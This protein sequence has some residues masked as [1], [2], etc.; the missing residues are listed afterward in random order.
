MTD[1]F[2]PSVIVLGL[3]AGSFVNVLIYRIPRNIDFVSLRS[4]CESCRKL[5]RWYQNIPVLSFILLRGRCA[6]CRQA[7]SWRHPLVEIIIAVGALWLF[8]G[9]WNWHNLLQFGFFFSVFCA[10]V[11]H[12]FIDLD[13]QVLP[14]GVNLYLAAVFW[15][16][17]L[18]FHPWP[19]WLGGGVVGFG[20]PYGVTWLFYRVRKKIGMGGGISSSTGPWACTW[21]PSKLCSPCF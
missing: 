19:H 12:F 6:Y 8:P 1:L 4:R 21:G 10:F 20:V 18:F 7:I 17:S 9:Y 13:F 16:H 15:A 11:T 2:Y 3:L 14:D 5:I